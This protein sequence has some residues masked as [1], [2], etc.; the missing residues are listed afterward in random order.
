MKN[1]KAVFC[2][3]GMMLCIGSMAK[4]TVEDPIIEMDGEQPRY[5]KFVGENVENNWRF[6][7]DTYGADGIKF[8][9]TLERIDASKAA[10]LAVTIEGAAKSIPF[11]SEVE[12]FNTD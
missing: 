2:L 4:I 10:A 1:L 8:Q 6:T 3:L 5:L 11:M 9:L 7:L 12:L